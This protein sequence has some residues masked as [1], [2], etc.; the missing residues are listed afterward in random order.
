[1][2]FPSK[3]VLQST[4]EERRQFSKGRT[5]VNEIYLITQTVC[6]LLRFWTGLFYYL[7][8]A[9]S[10]ST[11]PAS[12]LP[13]RGLFRRAFL[14]ITISGRR[15]ARLLIMSRTQNLNILGL[16]INGLQQSNQIQISII[17]AQ[18][19]QRIKKN[20]VDLESQYSELIER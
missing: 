19:Y 11:C 17:L 20:T 9:L 14:F 18:W 13:L 16:S 7:F 15:T 5:P 12:S 3:P 8:V 4:Q 6:R 10:L 2:Y 1:M